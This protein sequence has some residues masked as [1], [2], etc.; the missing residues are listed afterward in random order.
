VWQSGDRT[1]DDGFDVSDRTS[2]DEVDLGDRTSGDEVDVAIALRKFMK[3]L[4]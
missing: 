1:F 3:R 4:S 2:G